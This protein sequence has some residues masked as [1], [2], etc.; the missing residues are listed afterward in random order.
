MPSAYIECPQCQADIR[1]RPRD[2][3]WTRC[4]YCGTEFDPNANADRT[5]EPLDWM[6]D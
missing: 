6:G 1:L 3:H 4:R 2:R 5:G